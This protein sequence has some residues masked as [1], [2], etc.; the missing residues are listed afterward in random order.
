MLEL[1][2]PT[3]PYDL[4]RL[5]GGGFVVRAAEPGETLLTLDDVERKLGDGPFPDCLIC[6]AEGTPVG[7]GGVMGGASSEISESTTRVVLEAAYFDRMAIARTS[8]R[9]GLRSEAS[10]RFERGCDPLGIDRAVARFVELLG[11]SPRTGPFVDVRDDGSMPAQPR[12]V[13]RTSRVNALLGTT[14]TDAQVREQLEPIGFT[15]S[16]EGDGVHDVVAPS[17]RPDVE[18]EVDLIEEVARH[19]GYARIPRTVPSSPHVG[20]LTAYQRERRLVRDVLCGLGLSEAVGPMLLGPGDHARAGLA[21]GA[22]DVIDA[23]DPLA[24]EESILRT[25]MLPGLLRAVAFNAGHRNPDVWFFEIGHVYLPAPSADAPLPD[26]RERLAFALAGPGGGADART[27]AGVLRTLFDALR[28]D[29]A[30][31]PATAPGLHPTRTAM[32]GDGLGFVGEVDPAVLATHAIDGRVGWC[33]LEL[34]ALLA[35]PRRSDEMT[36]VSRYPSSDLDLAFA[37]PDATAAAAVESTIRASAGELLEWVRL[38]DVFRG[39]GGLGAGERS[40]AFRLRLRALDRTLTDDELASLRRAVVDAVESRH[41]ARL[42][43]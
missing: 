36:P 13:L 28:L 40:L 11:G 35:V 32:V 18:G 31:T 23:E 30:L 16:A 39:G 38:F 20:G 14:L 22:G 27:A 19:H 9:I 4:D 26:E 29:V 6:D 8:K 43:G 21:E 42:R 3:H 25:S 37:V 15:V 17:Y 1:G 7:I 10:A 34:P 41:S 33:E 12:I 5:P 2:Q 24:R